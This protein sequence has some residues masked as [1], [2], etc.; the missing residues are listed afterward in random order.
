MGFRDNLSRIP[1]AKGTELHLLAFRNFS[2]RT[3]SRD[4]IL[5]NAPGTSGSYRVFH[6]AAA[7]NQGL[8][9]VQTARRMLETFGEIVVQAKDEPG[10]HQNVD[11][12]LRFVNEE[13]LLKF[14]CRVDGEYF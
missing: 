13:G 6:A 3:P 2:I 4:L 10:T 8:I 5:R 7:A 9:D 1:P 11:F 12:L 14:V